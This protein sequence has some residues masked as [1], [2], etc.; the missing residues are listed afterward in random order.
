MYI[1]SKCKSAEQFNCALAAW[2]SGIVSASHRGDWSYGSWDRIPPGYTILKVRIHLLS[3]IGLILMSWSL[4][5]FN[6]HLKE[7]FKIFDTQFRMPDSWTVSFSSKCLLLGGRGGGQ[8]T[9]LKLFASTANSSMPVCFKHSWMGP[10]YVQHRCGAGLPDDIFS[11]PKS[12][13]G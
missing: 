8:I 9:I 7:V 12:Q 6:Y 2:S 4:V 1:L 5:M 13:F 11:N 3:Y 10:L